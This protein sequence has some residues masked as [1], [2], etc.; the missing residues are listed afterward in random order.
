MFSSLRIGLVAGALC[1][2]MLL[3]S[4]P[5]Q[6]IVIG[7]P[8]QVQP[9]DLGVPSVFYVDPDFA[10]GTRDGQ[11]STPWQ[12]LADTTTNT[13]W[14]VI[15]T[16]LDA[17]PVTVY[18]SCREAGS[19]TAEVGSQITMNRTSTSGRRLTLDGMTKWNQNDS[20]PSWADY[21][22]SLTRSTSKHQV[23]NTA[24]NGWSI[25]WGGG[26][27]VVAMDDV[28]IRGF[29]STG[30]RARFRLEGGGSRFI[31]EYNYVHDVSDG[32]PGMQFNAGA[33][34]YSDGPTTSNP[35]GV[36]TLL[37][38]HLSDDVIFRYNVINN[39]ADEGLY[40]GGNGEDGN[41]EG[42]DCP[43]HTNIQ[44]IGN[45]VSNP[46]WGS[47]GEGDCFDLKNGNRNITYRD[48]IVGPCIRNGIP[49]IGAAVSYLPQTA[50]IENNLVHDTNTAGGTGAIALIN[51]WTTVPSGVTIRN[52][53]VYNGSINAADGN[54]NTDGDGAKYN[55]L[56]DNNTIDEGEVQMKYINTG[57]LRNNVILHTS[58]SPVITYSQTS[59]F[60]EDYNAVYQ[61][62]GSGANKITLTGGQ[63]AGLFTNRAGRDYSLASGSALLNVGVTIGTFKADRIGTARPQGAAWDI[64][65]YERP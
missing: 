4:A 14:T 33:Y 28:T 61:A 50:V 36:C 32:G 3:P 52:N 41:G 38:T 43:G 16:A 35:S 34:A 1:A 46:A 7:G 59:S 58:T 24:G 22:G 47:V 27:P 20:T 23:S 6:V 12:S 11:A 21:G 54:S 29:E 63:L 44:F 65:A 30:S 18:F 19:D 56:I 9:P 57:A 45:T 8:P 37:V 25:G 26:P 64:G 13:P 31:V 60:T 55:I 62:G 42:F 53:V 10:G 51:T 5:E 40:F 17:G 15:N 2:Q 49:L 48:N 39:T